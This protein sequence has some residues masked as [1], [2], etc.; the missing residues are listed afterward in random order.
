M[1]LSSHPLASSFYVL[2][3]KVCAATT[4][5]SDFSYCC[6]QI[7]DKS[8]F[9]KQRFLSAHSK[10]ALPIK[11]TGTGGSWSQFIHRGKMGREK[12]WHP[13][14]F[15]FIKTRTPSHGVGAVHIQDGSSCSAKTFWKCT[16]GHTWVCFHGDPEPSE[17]DKISHPRMPNQ[18]QGSPASVPN[19]DIWNLLEA[20]I[21]S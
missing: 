10:Q 19:M 3:W 20:K 12:C 18:P 4:W 13:A 9:R 5:L 11:A 16:H 15:L 1:A 2:G 14:R 8:D 7:P 6:D 17:A 21:V